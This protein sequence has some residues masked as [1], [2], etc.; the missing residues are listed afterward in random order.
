[1][2]SR[3]DGAWCDQISRQSLQDRSRIA[4][5]RRS[6]TDP[7]T[8]K[9]LHSGAFYAARRGQFTP[10]VQD[11][12]VKLSGCPGALT[13]CRFPGSRWREMAVEAV[14]GQVENRP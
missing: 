3:R 14:T 8:M 6:R 11:G 2:D 9:G 7:A 10:W 12:K 13:P 5:G 4:P 1:M